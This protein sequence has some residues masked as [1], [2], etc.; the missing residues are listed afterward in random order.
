MLQH[1]GPYSHSPP[2]WLCISRAGAAGC[3]ARGLGFAGGGGGCLDAAP[4]ELPTMPPD[5]VCDAEQA[6]PSPPVCFEALV[7]FLS[8]ETTDALSAGVCPAPRLPTAAEAS[9][10]LRQPSLPIDESVAAVRSS[11]GRLCRLLAPAAPH[12]ADD[13]VLL[14]RAVAGH[15]TFAAA[16]VPVPEWSPASTSAAAW[17]PSSTNRRLSRTRD[18]VEL[19][20]S[21]IAS[22]SASTYASATAPCPAPKL[23]TNKPPRRPRLS[24]L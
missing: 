8:P 24:G 1:R 17:S 20:A 6:S 11:R 18:G 23:P 14:S 9:P 16:S 4:A 19:L 22:A 21:A 2:R 13:T 15:A 5:D 7:T 3:L 12:F 10:R